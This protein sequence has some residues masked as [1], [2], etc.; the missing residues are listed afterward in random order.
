MPKIKAVVR[1]TIT[2]NIAESVFWPDL[3]VRSDISGTGV[4]KT[5]IHHGSP[6]RSG[7]YHMNQ[8]TISDSASME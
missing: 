2:E 7:R 3:N 6:P 5:Q 1:H 4:G 8:Y